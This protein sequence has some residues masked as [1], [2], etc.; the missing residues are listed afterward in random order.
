[1]KTLIYQSIY[2]LIGSIAVLAGLMTFLMMFGLFPAIAEAFYSHKVHILQEFGCALVFLGLVS[3]WC[4]YNLGK[5]KAIN[6]ILVVFFGLFSLLH[7]MDFFMGNLSVVSALVNSVPL[8]VL[9]VM[10]NYY[11]FSKTT[12]N[13]RID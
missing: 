11:D 2:R 9:S 3:F 10:H 5:C 6:L 1:M 8:L 13:A 4:S 12:D 7:W